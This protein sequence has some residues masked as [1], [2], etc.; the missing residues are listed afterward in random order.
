MSI[1]TIKKEVSKL[2]KEEQTELM[3]FMIELLASENPS[4]SEEWQE[5]INHREEA[6]NNGTSVG[7]PAKQVIA[8]YFKSKS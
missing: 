5:E 3:H 6:L 1:Q 8:K 7:K 4:I 2:K